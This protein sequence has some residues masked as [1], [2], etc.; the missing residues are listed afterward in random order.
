MECYSFWVVWTGKKAFCFGSTS[1]FFSNKDVNLTNSKSTV[2][3]PHEAQ[4]QFSLYLLR[5][6]TDKY[7]ESEANRL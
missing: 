6:T 1:F 3:K 5:E 2:L 7:K 4:Q